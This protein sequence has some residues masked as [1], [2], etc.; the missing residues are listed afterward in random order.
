MV[1]YD[2]SFFQTRAEKLYKEAENVVFSYAFLGGLVGV[3][4][5]VTAYT[6]TLF[7]EAMK[8]FADTLPWWLVELGPPIVG[9]SLGWARGRKTAFDLRFRAQEILWKIQVEKNT[10]K[11]TS[12]AAT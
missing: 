1:I 9:L 7:A 12:K 3:A 8:H 10:R 11:E 2:A 5:S 6:A 4:V